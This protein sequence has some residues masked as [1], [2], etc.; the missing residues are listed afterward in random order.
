MPFSS[1]FHRQPS[2]R[3]RNFLFSIDTIVCAPN[4]LFCLSW[5]LSSF[6]STQEPAMTA[7]ASVCWG[8]NVGELLLCTLH[9]LQVP[10]SVAVL[11][12]RSKT[13]CAAP[14][15]RFIYTRRTS[16][17]N[18]ALTSW[19]RKS[20]WSACLSICLTTSLSLTTCLSLCSV[21]VCV[22]CIFTL[23]G[24]TCWLTACV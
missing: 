23:F 8:C 14:W 18:L 20:M 2:K 24:V 3:A 16:F 6:Y 4:H 17:W 13:T 15:E 12:R 5:N 19:R 7:V 9:R 10:F 22:C 21:C 1:W 11:F